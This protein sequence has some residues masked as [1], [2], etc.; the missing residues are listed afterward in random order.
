MVQSMARYG[1]DLDGTLWMIPGVTKLAR[2]LIDDG[3]KVYIITGNPDKDEIKQRLDALNIVPHKVVQ[4]PAANLHEKGEQKGHEANKHKLSIF[5]EDKQDV[6]VGFAGTSRIARGYTPNDDNL[7]PA[8]R[9]LCPCQ[10]QI[11][12]EFTPMRCYHCTEFLDTNDE[13]AQHSREHHEDT[14]PDASPV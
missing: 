7:Q 9:E 14:E 8:K 6:M 5:F 2:D 3:H 13:R 10:R 1:F 11:R 4:V 12:G